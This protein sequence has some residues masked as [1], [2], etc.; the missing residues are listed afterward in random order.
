[1][2]KQGIGLRLSDK[3][4]ECLAENFGGPNVGAGYVEFGL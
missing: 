1:M 3:A 2:A 4:R